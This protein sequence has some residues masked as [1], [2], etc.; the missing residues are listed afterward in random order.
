MSV[1]VSDLDGLSDIEAIIRLEREFPGWMC[2]RGVNRLVYGRAHD[3]PDL[4]RFRE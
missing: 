3:D 1:S 4:T 2:F